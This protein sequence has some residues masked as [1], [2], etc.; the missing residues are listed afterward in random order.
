M[1]DE[2]SQGP[3]PG[4][5]P[6]YARHKSEEAHRAK[7]LGELQQVIMA[8]GLPVLDIAF[9]REDP[10]V[11]MSALGRGR[12]WRTLKRRVMVWKRCNWPR[13]VAHILDNLGVMVAER[14]W[15][16]GHFAHGSCF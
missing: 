14:G 11:L 8:S 16:L 2:H 10:N 5:R 15:P 3:R 6:P 9:R 4:W 12:R 1:A 13:D 7:W